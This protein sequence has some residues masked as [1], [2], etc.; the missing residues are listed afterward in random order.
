MC[1]H[2]ALGSTVGGV[3]CEQRVILSYVL[4][5]LSET[6]QEQNNNTVHLFQGRSERKCS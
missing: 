4:V 3:Q 5:L 2:C 6:L 1:E